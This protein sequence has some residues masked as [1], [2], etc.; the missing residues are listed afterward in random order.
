MSSS[1][2]V[3]PQ[4]SLAPESQ[5]VN[6]P[7]KPMKRRVR[8]HGT[9]PVV[10]PSE[11]IKPSKDTQMSSEN[12]V[13]TSTQ[14]TSIPISIMDSVLASSSQAN[15]GSESAQEGLLIQTSNTPITA[16]SVDALDLDQSSGELPKSG[17]NDSL[18]MNRTNLEDP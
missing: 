11:P 4:T 7:K 9:S 17:S 6:V 14:T 18:V 12:V 1:K 10:K 5:V 13:G 2:P 15:I 8:G 16:R 3:S